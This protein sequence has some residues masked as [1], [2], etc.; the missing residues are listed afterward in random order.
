MIEHVYRG[1]RNLAPRGADFM[2]GITPDATEGL[3]VS[4][5]GRPLAMLGRPGR[6]TLPEWGYDGTGP[7]VLAFTLL[8][9]THGPVVAGRLWDAFR[10]EVVAR[11]PRT[12]GGVEWRMTS[13]EI[14]SWVA[15]HPPRGVGA[16][17]PAPPAN[18]SNDI[19][20]SL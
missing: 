13:S 6:Q 10:D 1:I 5:D 7:G 3:V 4:K 11:W 2:A 16:R 19:I 15:A 12:V 9:D 14:A 17:P 18:L 20:E 8:H